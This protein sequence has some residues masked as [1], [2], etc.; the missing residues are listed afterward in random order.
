MRNLADSS[1]S[2][3][4][5]PV[6]RDGCPDQAITA[7]SLLTLEDFNRVLAELG[8]PEVTREILAPLYAA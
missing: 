3:W 8:L 5:L 7:P 2:A 6:Q 1:G 4:P